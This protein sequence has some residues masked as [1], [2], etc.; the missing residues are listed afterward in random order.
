MI[1]SLASIEVPYTSE[2]TEYRFVI[3][4]FVQ[5]LCKKRASVDYC[6]SIIFLICGRVAVAAGSAS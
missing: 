6:P 5:Y 2:E 4:V 1:I 3:K